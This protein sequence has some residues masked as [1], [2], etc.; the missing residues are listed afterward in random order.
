MIKMISLDTILFHV[1]G[2]EF[3]IPIESGAEIVSFDYRYY[4]S[5]GIDISVS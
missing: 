3:V 2:S 4:F 1:M 5:F